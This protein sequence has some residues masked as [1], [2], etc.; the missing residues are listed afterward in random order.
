[1]RFFDIKRA[2]NEILLL[3]NS[4]TKTIKFVDRTFNADLKRAHEIFSFIV[5]AAARKL[6]PAGVCF[7][8]EMAGDLFD[9]ELFA[10]LAA[11]PLGLYQFE[12]GIQSFNEETL[13]LVRR[14][15]D[16]R[17]LKQNI[18]RLIA[19]KNI[20]IH[21]DLIAGLPLEDLH[22]FAEGFNTA[23]SLR[24]HMLQLG[25]LKLLHGAEMRLNPV[26]YPC[27]FYDAPPYAVIKT[28]WMPFEAI[29]QIHRAETALDR[30]Y[31]KGRFHRTLAYLQNKT[32]LDAFALFH[33]IGGVCANRIESGISLDKLLLLL[34]S[35]YQ[36]KPGIS[37]DALRDMMVCDCLA[38]GRHR[39][40]PPPLRIIREEHKSYDLKNALFQRKQGLRNMLAVRLSAVAGW[41][42]ANTAARDVVTGDYPI[43]VFV[44]GI[45]NFSAAKRLYEK[46]TVADRIAMI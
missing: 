41:V 5:D 20:H 37:A 1:V 24:P 46:T 2:K 31:N 16:V 36:S 17:I 12:I 35:H 29:N 9:D 28:P 42:A 19:M 13:A 40:I 22:Q 44:F 33:E 14:K 18:L 27:D 43:D 3:A 21:V 26:T 38:T 39:Q 6:L 7:H 25:F 8:F 30:L 34:Y 15:T 32:R 23:Y 11:A 45:E 10:L 4:H